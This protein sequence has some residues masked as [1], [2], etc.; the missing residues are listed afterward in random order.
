MRVLSCRP[1]AVTDGS[2][3]SVISSVSS[4]YVLWAKKNMW[5]GGKRSKKMRTN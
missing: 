4:D 3:T 2:S 1:G 5:C